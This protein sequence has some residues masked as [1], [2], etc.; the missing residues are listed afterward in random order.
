MANTIF[1]NSDYIVIEYM[2]LIKSPYLVF[3]HY[4]RQNEKLREIL[5][6]EQIEFLNDFSLYEWYINRKHQNFLVD[7]NRFPDEISESDLYE[8]LNIQMNNSEMMYKEATL[9]PL[10]T[11]LPIMLSKK[12]ATKDIIIYHPHKNDF[13][14]KNLLD[15]I[16]YDLKFMDNFDE[17]LD[18]AK[19]NSTYFLSD[20]DKIITMKDKGY[21]KCSSITLPIEYR[22]N[23]KNMEDFKYDF[24]QLYKDNPHKISFIRS[25]TTTNDDEDMS[26]EN[27]DNEE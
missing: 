19:E 17:V 13:A 16:G 25:C 6:I 10:G 8:L 11:R 27:D 21:L 1:F 18:V 4:I 7:L 5:K 14:K 20:I 9:L 12:M 26:I 3:L 22:Y 2:D 15:E 24:H 23:K